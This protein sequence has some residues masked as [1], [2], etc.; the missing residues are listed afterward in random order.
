MGG[1]LLELR[2]HDS[3]DGQ[4]HHGLP[5]TNGSVPEPE[6]GEQP[7]DSA[8]ELVLLRSALQVEQSGWER[9]HLRALARQLRPERH[10]LSG[11]TNPKDAAYQRAEQPYEHWP[12]EPGPLVRSLVESGQPG[13]AVLGPDQGQQGGADRLYAVVPAGSRANRRRQRTSVGGDFTLG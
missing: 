8:G 3:G 12:T 5:G 1:P 13:R 7:G 9:R 10:Q 2:E 11:N 4:R 6:H